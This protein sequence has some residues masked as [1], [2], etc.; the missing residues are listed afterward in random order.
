MLC[1]TTVAGRG[2][3]PAAPGVPGGPNVQEHRGGV[4]PVRTYQD[5]L[6][7]AH[8]EALFEYYGTSQLAMVNAATG[9]RT[10]LGRPGLHTQALPS[11]DGQYMLVTTA[12]RVRSRGSCR[13]ATSA[14]LVEVWDRVGAITK[15]AG[16]AAGGR[17]RAERRRAAGAARRFRWHPT[18][19]ATLAW[20]EALD[21]GDPKTRCR[22]A[23]WCSR[24]R[25]RSRRAPAEL[26]RTEYRFGGVAWTDAGVAL[27]TENDRTTRRTR[28]WVFDRAGRGAAQAMGSQRRGRATAIRAR[29]CAR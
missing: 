17:R 23:I 18:E 20:A 3:A 10:A 19:P 15:T 21:G 5:L 28:T 11:P 7:S 1:A 9:A 22:I 24:W 29:R 6:T 2:A 14:R 12:R 13:T 16:H 8:D 26:A 4:A 27:V 25:R